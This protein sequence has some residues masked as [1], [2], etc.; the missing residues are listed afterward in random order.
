V[1]TVKRF[2]NPTLIVASATIILL[3][4][5]L[6][7]L[8]GCGDSTTTTTAAATETTAAAST[9]T[10]APGGT[11]TSAATGEPYK[12]GLICDLT[13]PI[14]AIGIDVRDGTQLEVDRVNAAGGVNGRPIE[15]IVADSGTD[16]AKGNAA[17]TKLIQQD[18]VLGIIG[19]VWGVLLPQAQAIAER[20]QVPLIS[21]APDESTIVKGYKWS[22]TVVQS[23]TL[24]GQAVIKM[25]ALDGYKT[26]VGVSEIQNLYTKSMEVA[27]QE[28]PAAGIN[29]VA[30]PDQFSPGD[31]DMSSIATKIKDAVDKNNAD[32]IYIATN[33]LDAVTMI[34][35]LRN[36]GVNQPIIGTHAYGFQA[37]ID[38]GGADVEGVTFPSD[39]SIVADQ[40]PDSD[41]RKPLL[42]DFGKAYTEKTGRPLS[43]FA[44]HA[45]TTVGMYVEGIKA[46]DTDRQ[47]I[48]DAIEGL[49]DFVGSEGIFNYSPT[50]HIGLALD[51]FVVETVKDGTF[52]LTRPSL[53]Q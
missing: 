38:A 1:S 19:P 52:V 51:S 40:L 25:A 8:A 20:D 17:I 37:M 48:R 42:L 27:A 32:A 43:A 2:T 5:S 30:V 29:F 23:G 4:V 21:Y 14:S 24:L 36:L 22:F 39:P 10:T 3:L 16:S 6:L 46:G 49:K 31:V 41:P 12:L 11:G 13:G 18:K 7:A 35:A 34:K 44:A 33:G 50:D 53:V 15:L 9:D 26:V 47:K 45:I 28:A